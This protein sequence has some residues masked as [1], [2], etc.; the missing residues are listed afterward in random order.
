MA[1]CEA[2]AKDIF[3]EASFRQPDA[4]FCEKPLKRGSGTA[5][6]HIHIL[7]HFC[8]MIH[9]ILSQHSIPFEYVEVAKWKGALPKDVHH[10]R[11]LRNIK[12]E[13]GIDLRGKSEDEI[14]AIGLGY[15][16]TFKSS[17]LPSKDS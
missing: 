3:Y 7:V 14:D 5:S 13:Y 10:P 15:W 9:G 17:Y 16:I 8:G 1:R 2:I 11:I 4:V 6:G 12:E